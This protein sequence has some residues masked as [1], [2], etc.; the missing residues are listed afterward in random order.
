MTDK[1][2]LYRVTMLEGV[3]FEKELA[4]RIIA[5]NARFCG[6]DAW[7]PATAVDG[8]RKKTLLS[9]TL[10]GAAQAHQDRSRNSR[11]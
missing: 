10:R 4:V 3:P 5:F 9:S 11:S 6:R 2:A 1:E 7:L 8:A